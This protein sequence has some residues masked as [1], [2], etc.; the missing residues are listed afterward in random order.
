MVHQQFEKAAALFWALGGQIPHDPALEESAKESVRSF[1]GR[2][3][4][5]L[6]AAALCGEGEAPCQRYLLAKIYSWLGVAYASQTIRWASAYLSG[7]P[8]DRLPS[9]MTT[10]DGI[11]ISQESAIRASLFSDMAQAQMQ[12]GQP[13]AALNN[14][15]QAYRLE[16][17]NAMY[18]VK[19]AD[20]LLRIRTPEEAL[21]YLQQQTSSAYYRPVRYTDNRGQSKSNDTF[22]QLLDAQIRKIQALQQNSL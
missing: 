20:L 8:W 22:R 4:A 17:Y 2:E 7:D 3:K 12:S 16:P 18:P 5:L 19:I 1:S 15:E 14:Y 6:K 11:T 21:L 10:Q 13:L 9:G